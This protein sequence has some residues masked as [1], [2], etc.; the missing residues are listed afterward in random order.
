MI[1]FLSVSVCSLTKKCINLSIAQQS[2]KIYSRKD[3]INILS[4]KIY[5]DSKQQY[6]FVQLNYQ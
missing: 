6:H 3:K 4:D 1:V 5:N 2:E